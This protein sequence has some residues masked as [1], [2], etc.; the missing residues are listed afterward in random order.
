MIEYLFDYYRTISPFKFTSSQKNGGQH[1]QRNF[2]IG[3]T[4]TFSFF[5]ANKILFGSCI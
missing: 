2:K 1:M 5:V 4:M 3:K